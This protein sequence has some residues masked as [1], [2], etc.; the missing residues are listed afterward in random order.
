MADKVYKQRTKSHT[1]TLEN[2]PCIGTLKGQE[3]PVIKIP[4]TQD[5]GGHAIGHVFLFID[6][7]KEVLRQVTLIKQFINRVEAEKAFGE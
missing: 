3:L 2:W 5:W 4:Y 1:A 7:A 6:E